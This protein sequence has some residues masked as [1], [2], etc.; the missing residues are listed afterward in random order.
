MIRSIDR[1]SVIAKRSRI[2]NLNRNICTTLSQNLVNTY[3]NR[4]YL[5]VIPNVITQEEEKEIFSFLDP[6]L[7][8][9][10]YQQDH[11]DSVITKYKEKEVRNS[12]A[13]IEEIW[14]KIRSIIREHHGEHLKFLA[15][16]VIDLGEEGYIGPHID[17]VKVSGD[18]VCGLSLL[19]CR[20]MRL[21]LDSEFSNMYASEENAPYEIGHRKDLEINLAPRSLYML[22]GPYRYHYTHSVLC[23]CGS[24]TTSTSV[25]DPNCT[26]GHSSRRLSVMFRDEIDVPKKKTIFTYVLSL[27]FNLFTII[28]LC[29]IYSYSFIYRCILSI[30]L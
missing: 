12:P 21:S 24:Q 9:M 16:H 29:C 5:Q 20:T 17:S 19:S 1:L 25:K 27:C 30:F 22:S 11:W 18:L 10:R 14:G 7:A 4:D 23:N 6:I 3:Y 15:P 8:R 26:T 28:I 13:K 2:S